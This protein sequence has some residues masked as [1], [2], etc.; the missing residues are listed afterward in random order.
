M[1][2][3]NRDEEHY[4]GSLVENFD[5]MLS[6][7]NERCEE[8]GVSDLEKTKSLSIMLCG[9]DLQFY[10]DLIPGKGHDYKTLTEGVK[11][12]SVTVYHSRTPLRDLDSKAQKTHPKKHSYTIPSEF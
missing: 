6:M 5:R 10:L 12:R 3:H 11:K 1:K 9:R 4:E 2:F 7:F 8:A